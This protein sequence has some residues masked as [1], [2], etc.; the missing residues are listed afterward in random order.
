MSLSRKEI[1]EGALVGKL[2][3]VLLVVFVEESG[4]C[5]RRSPRRGWEGGL[6]EMW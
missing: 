4:D 1:G 5:R 2:E 6:R 3:L